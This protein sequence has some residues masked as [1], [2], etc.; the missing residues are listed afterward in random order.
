MKILKSDLDSAEKFITA[1][2]TEIADANALIE[3]VNQF[4]SVI[5]LKTSLSGPGYDSIK[6][7][8]TEYIM[9][10]NK[11]KDT[12]LALE[13]A[14]ITALNKMNGYIEGYSELDDSDIPELEAK[15]AELESRLWKTYTTSTGVEIRT[16]NHA[17][18]AVIIATKKMIEK[19]KQLQPTDG[20]AY[21]NI[22]NVESFI[23]SFKSSISS[24][25]SIDVSNLEIPNNEKPP[26][27]SVSL[28]E[29]D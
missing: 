26:Q 19:L 2:E 15:I 14:I 25:E 16:K 6:N 7:K 28:G 1:L 13:G 23:Q 18:E 11:R 5:S 24:L 9:L 4:I 27:V 17:V 12:A 8:L 21:Q 3:N 22:T 20:A 10:I 29:K